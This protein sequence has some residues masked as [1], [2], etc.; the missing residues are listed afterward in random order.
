M[1]L[2]VAKKDRLR[3]RILEAI[4]SGKWEKNLLSVSVEE[5][6]NAVINKGIPR[7]AQGVN[8]A[9]PIME[10]FFSQLLPYVENV[11]KEIAEMPDVTIDDAINRVTTFIRRMHEFQFI[12]KRR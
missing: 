4:D 8:E 2:A 1:E 9:K 6:K 12:R 11:R 10:D 5:W 7:I 3:A